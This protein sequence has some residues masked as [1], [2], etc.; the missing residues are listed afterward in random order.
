MRSKDTICCTKATCKMSIS[1]THFT[2]QIGPTCGGSSGGRTP[3]TCTKTRVEL[4]EAGRM[5][6][7]DRWSPGE[8]TGSV[9]MCCS[10]RFTV[11][12][13]RGPRR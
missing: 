12:E 1:E 5:H 10:R 8:L 7:E 11:I 4:F 2:T 6:P 3:S 9:R 13:V